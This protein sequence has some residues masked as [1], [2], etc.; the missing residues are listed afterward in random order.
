MD[1]NTALLSTGTSGTLLTLLYF[2]LRSVLGKKI[3]SRC[4]NKD[5]E[6]GFQVE[7]MTPPRSKTE[8]S[9]YIE[10]PIKSSNGEHIQVAIT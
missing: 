8:T 10:N 3:R 2:I 4:C 5:I 1:S 6:V 9:G 7:N